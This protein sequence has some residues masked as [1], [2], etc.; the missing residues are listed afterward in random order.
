[1]NQK[2]NEAR[3]NKKV[4]R[5]TDKLKTISDR[6]DKII[7]EIAS[8]SETSSAYWA[9]INSR[10]RE[11]YEA[12]RRTVNEWT[13]KELPK[14]FQ[15]SLRKT[16]TDLKYKSI[17]APKKIK[18]DDFASA[19][20]NKQSLKSILNETLA[21][22]E[23]GFKQ[24]QNTLTR[25]ASLTQQTLLSEKQ[26]TKAIAEGFIEKGS[27]NASKKRLQKE[28]LN[29]SL[30]GKYITIIDKN[31][32]PEQWKVD[33]YAELV[34][35]TKLSEASAQAVFNTASA[36]GADLVQISAHN[37]Q[38]KICIEFEG[39]IFSLSGN[40]RDFPALPEGPPFHPNCQHSMSIVFKE[41]LQRDG[42]L[43]KYIAFSNDESEIHPTRKSFIPRSE[44]DLK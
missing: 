4:S 42:T 37:T 14:E 25:L 13:L 30:D 19:N 41:A 8:T 17:S 6:I 7:I 24:G 40:D 16:L 23:S 20:I 32:K 34:A 36:V 10:L 21:S 43:D 38:T 27:A 5:L 22:Y 3:I 26:V 18:Y 39:K 9:K 1:M 28:L 15:D 29:K 31:G 11:Q 44:R 2:E 33:T 35:R 12:L